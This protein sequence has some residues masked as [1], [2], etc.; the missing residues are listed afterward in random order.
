MTSPIPAVYKS[1]IRATSDLVDELNA[2]GLFSP[3]GF[4]NFEE[5]GPEKDLPKITLVGVDGFSFD[6]NQGRW[7]IR[8]AVAVSS[9]RDANLLNEIEMIG[10]IQEKWG[11]GKKITLLDPVDGSIDNEM[12]VS[13]FKMM[14]MAQSELRNYRTIGLEILRTGITRQ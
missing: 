2:S 8:Y 12:V 3:I 14:P 4:H 13:A 6:E 7:L 11:E 1:I 9:F 10:L 5:R